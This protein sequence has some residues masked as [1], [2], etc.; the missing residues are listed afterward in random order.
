MTGPMTKAERNSLAQ[1]CRRRERLAKAGA[2][3][4]AAILKSDFEKQIAAEY[5]YDDDAVWKQANERVEKVVQS[6]RREIAERCKELGIPP[7]FAPGL[8]FDW[9]GRGQNAIASRR[10]EFCKV[11]FGRIDADMKKAHH[12]IEE[13]SLRVQTS[14]L[15]GALQSDEAKAFLA[16]MPEPD[17]LMPPLVLKE[18]EEGVVKP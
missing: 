14:L 5:S 15:A 3:S 2:I 9:Y 13:A 8:S 1:L 12:Q 17:Q 11:G 7:Q 18:I 10:A 4:R 6:A 16:S